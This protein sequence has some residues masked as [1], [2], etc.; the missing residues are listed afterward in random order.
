MCG[1]VGYVGTSDSWPI[2]FAGLHRLSYR[3][4]DSA[5]IAVVGPDG[6]LEIR[7]SAGKVQ[8]LEPAPGDTLPSGTTGIGHTR[9]ATHGVPNDSN[10]HPHS[11]CASNIALVHNGI[12][13]NYLDL[14]HSLTAAGHQFSSDTDTEVI[15]HLLED[16]LGR[17]FSFEASLLEA[18][19][20][21]R[22]AN[23]IG[24]LHRGEPNKLLA[25]RLGYAGGLV[26]ASREG[27]A[28]FASDLPA[29]VPF[30]SQ[31]CTLDDAEMAIITPDKVK[32]VGRGGSAVVKEP[33]SV[34]P[35]SAWVDKDGHDHFMLKEI[36]EQ[37]QAISSALRGRVDF[38]RGLVTLDDF[39]LSDT[40][41]RALSRVILVGCGTSFN[42]GILGAR[43]IEEL[44]GIPTMA[45]SS[46]E[47]RYQPLAIDHRTLVVAIG[48][49]GETADTLAAMEA[50]RQ[51]GAR[52]ITI[53]NVDGS[54]ATRTAEHTLY[55]RSGV[56]IG[57]AST[58][59]FVAS[60][61]LLSLL[62]AYLG[63][64]RG[65]SSTSDVVGQLARAPGLVGRVLAGQ[66]GYREIAQRY[67]RY[68][69]FLY[70]GRD[71]HYP[72]AVEGA[73]KLKEVSYIHAEAYPAGEM[74][75]GPIALID[76]RMPTVAI[77]T[78]GPLY[79]KMVGNIMEVKTRGGAVIALGTEGDTSLASLVD[80]IIYLPQCD[81]ILSPLLSVL[82]LQLLAYHIALRRGCDV[83][84]PRNLAKTVT[85]E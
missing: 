80:D 79:D 48:Q 83:D 63:Q 76:E 46:S 39:P 9:W 77:A 61:T 81:G 22:G 43:L 20:R 8:D 33:L 21:L 45:E 57:V 44:S 65:V 53:C 82:P 50:V 32:V 30:Y 49:S 7:K 52:L 4:Y 78:A 18:G 73:L 40:Q 34:P 16:F 10:A 15:V 68:S 35:E 85:V 62:A 75:H 64:A 41:V 5:G 26:A 13:E 31:V 37:P 71:L 36:L 6:R 12:V 47:L 72:I 28:M 60:L 29:L 59:T 1:I 23:V 69:H 14:K 11:D 42:A 3:G 25:M 51:H 38:E 74:K 24:A 66:E 84:Q 54:L 2:V 27:E 19:T 70:L 56:E 17:G 67:A 55:M 58:K